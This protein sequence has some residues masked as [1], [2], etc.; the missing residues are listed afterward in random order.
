MV[1]VFLLL[2]LFSRLA[3]FVMQM[4]RFVTRRKLQN[5]MG[6]LFGHLVEIE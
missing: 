5:G 6:T 2:F 3:G 1:L 4:D